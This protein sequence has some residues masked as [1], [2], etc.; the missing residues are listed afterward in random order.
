MYLWKIPILIFKIATRLQ[1]VLKKSSEKLW[2]LF[3]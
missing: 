2:S 3:Y 1:I